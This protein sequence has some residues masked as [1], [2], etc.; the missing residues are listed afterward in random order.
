MCVY[1]AGP[2][3][4]ISL[5]REKGR[6]PNSPPPTSSNMTAPA[7]AR[8]SSAATAAVGQPAVGGGAV[9]E[10]ENV[11]LLD[12]S[13]A[14]T[15]PPPPTSTS[16]RSRLCGS[17]HPV[18]LLVLFATE[19]CERFSYYGMRA[20]LVLYMIHVLFRRD[21]EEATPWGMGIAKAIFGDPD[22]PSK[23]ARAGGERAYSCPGSA[24]PCAREIEV[25]ALASRVYGTYT[26]LV[27][28]TPV[29]GGAIADRYTGQRFMVLLGGFLMAI[30][31]FLMAFPKAFFLALFF[32]VMGNGAFKPNCT[33]QL[34]RLYR[35][36]GSAQS[37]LRQTA[38]NLFYLGINVGAFFAPIIVGALRAM[39][40]NAT[41]EYC[42]SS[43][44]TCLISADADINGYH[45][46]FTAAGIG[47]CISLVIYVAGSAHLAPDDIPPP[48]L[49]R[50]WLALR[51]TASRLRGKPA[52]HEKDF[53]STVSDGSSAVP[54]ASTSMPSHPPMSTMIW[55]HR[56]RIA[57]F[58]AMV[59]LVV[60]FWG[61]YEQ[62]GNT[63]QLFASTEA[64]R[65][66]FHRFTVPSEW[67]QAINPLFIILFTPMMSVISN[68][69]AKTSSSSS[70]SNSAPRPRWR[71][72]EPHALTKMSVGCMLTAA[73][74]V[75]MAMAAAAVRV[76]RDPDGTPVFLS[77]APLWMLV[78]AIAVQTVGELLVSPVGL[79]FTT[80]VA[81]A[82][83]T[84]FFVGVWM[85]ASFFGNF[86]AGMLGTLYGAFEGT[87]S[88]GEVQGQHAPFFLLLASLAA[89]NAALLFLVRAALRKYLDAAPAASSSS[90]SSSSST[91]TGV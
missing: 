41:A 79:N 89:G 52:H 69:L 17:R 9:A 19:A 43:G 39:R 78:V 49:Q 56:H 20:L 44:K 12:A 74:Q 68:M 80:T 58:A 37:Q 4:R 57:A 3:S 40:G 65:N 77:K 83:M 1:G 18:G 84:S 31:H 51:R 13:G 48:N 53:L 26:A 60:L 90:S 50:T 42:D 15:I 36:S 33:V 25:Q 61:V 2:V 29:A 14:P 6:I 22:D 8:A 23:V 35:L 34:G 72:Q 81:P 63:V 88:D 73:A 32:L 75:I 85:T 70:S 24:I 16:S 76:R 91:G 62:G 55:Q 46:G 45:A 47:M 66:L 86:L 5:S 64:D 30:G 54:S 11:R 67:V 10:E 59:L 71:C 28:L 7:D 27:Y 38:F 21:Y 82:G 87:Q